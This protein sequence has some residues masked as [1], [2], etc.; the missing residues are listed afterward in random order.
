MLWDL[1]DP[2]A[3]TDSTTAQSSI[4]YTRKPLANNIVSLVHT[5]Y[6]V[7]VPRSKPKFTYKISN[8][9]STESVTSTVNYPPRNSPPKP[10]PYVPIG[11]DSDPISSDYSL[12]GSSDSSESGYFKRGQLHHNKLR[13]QRRN[14]KPNKKHS[15]KKCTKLTAK[16]IKDA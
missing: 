13:R 16:I 14:N 8:P 10:V 3:I 1:H 5:H 11:P 2:Q 4:F 7:S 15:I 9:P 12:L 6:L